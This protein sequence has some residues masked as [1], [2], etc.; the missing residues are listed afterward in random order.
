MLEAQYRTFWSK[1]SRTRVWT[2]N[3]CPECG[4]IAFGW[5]QGSQKMYLT[6][7][8]TPATGNRDPS[9]HKGPFK[10]HPR[11]PFL[12]DTWS[13][14]NKRHT[15]RLICALFHDSVLPQSSHHAWSGEWRS[16]WGSKLPSRCLKDICK[17]FC[18]SLIRALIQITVHSHHYFLFI[19]CWNI[20][21]LKKNPKPIFLFF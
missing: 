21:H 14:T 2:G 15:W 10:D 6:P 7:F 17:Q 16:M 18:Y 12:T 20:M 8:P 9:P 19:S 13:R 3:S 1:T 5:S 11:D 4:D